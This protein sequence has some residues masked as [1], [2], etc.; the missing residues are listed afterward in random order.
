M[1]KG[2]AITEN[3]KRLAQLHQFRPEPLLLMLC[4]LGGGFKGQGVW[5]NLALQKFLHREVRIYDEAVAGVK[6]RY[7]RRHRRWAQVLE[8][9][10]SR[11][12]GDVLHHDV[13]DEDGT[14][15][16]T[17]QP[18]QQ[19]DDDEDEDMN[20]DEGDGDGDGEADDDPLGPTALAAEALHECPK[21]TKYSPVFNTMYGQNML[22]TRSYQSALCKSPKLHRADIQ[23]TLCA[24]TRSTP[25]T[26]SCAS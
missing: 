23:S 14:P 20:D 4:A 26:T 15:Q 24:P 3:C 8:S 17:P 1:R 16:G 19:Q 12:L 21:P 13:D 10:R 5:H 25:M 11:R 2:E 22:T 6:L 7:N 18:R 9:G